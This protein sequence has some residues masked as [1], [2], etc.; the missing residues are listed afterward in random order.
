[1]TDSVVQ[2]YL[3]RKKAEAKRDGGSEETGGQLAE[4]FGA[5]GLLRGVRDRAIMLEL[6]C[7]DGRIV[8]IPYAYIARIEYDPA[9]GITLVTG[10][11]RFRIAGRNLNAEVR[12]NV[13]L[14][15][16]LTRQRVTWLREASRDEAL[17]AKDGETLIE[18]LSWAE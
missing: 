8:A 2:Q 11:R 17:A 6:R 1:M 13:R 9:D 4:D 3:R 7:K 16:S 10:A 18:G 5:F 12:P 15:E 14:F